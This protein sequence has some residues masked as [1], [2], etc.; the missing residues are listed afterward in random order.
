VFE[1]PKA[2]TVSLFV[3]LRDGRARY[4]GR[5][6]ADLRSGEYLPGED[7]SDLADSARPS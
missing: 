7:A 3:T 2:R 1:T 6:L 5:V 4:L